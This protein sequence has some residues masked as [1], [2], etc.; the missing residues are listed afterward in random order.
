MNP[1][2]IQDELL[3]SVLAFQGQHAFALGNLGIVS[4]QSR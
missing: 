1:T 3:L 4:A 2:D